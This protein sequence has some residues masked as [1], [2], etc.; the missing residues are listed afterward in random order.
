MYQTTS[1]YLAAFLMARGVDLLGTWPGNLLTLEFSDAEG[2]ATE[3][4]RE[5]QS[6]QATI[7]A[8]QYMTAILEVKRLIANSRAAA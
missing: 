3:A 4:A 1:L 2:E 5:W 6:G 8:R 7:N